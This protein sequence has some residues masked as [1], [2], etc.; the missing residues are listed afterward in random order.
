MNSD[1]ALVSKRFAARSRLRY[2]NGSDLKI[3]RV[4][5]PNRF[6]YLTSRNVPVR[7]Q[8]VLGRI[9]RL[10]IP[11]AWTD[12]RICRDPAGHLQAVGR[13]ARGR[14]QYRYHDRWSRLRNENK[15]DRL[16]D[17]G[18]VLPKIRRA[19]SRDLRQPALTQ[20]KVLAAIVRLLESS[21][22]RVGNEEYVAQN[23]SYGL[24][25]LRNHHARVSG[26][27][28]KLRFRGKSG[29]EQEIGIRDPALARIVRKC[30]H[31]PGQRL[32][33]YADDDGVHAVSS[34]D[35]NDYLAGITGQSFTAKDFRTWE[36]TALATLTL[37]R[38]K[39][40]GLKARR[41]NIGEAIAQAAKHLGNTPAICKKCYIHPAILERYLKDA[42]ASLPNG[43]KPGIRSRSGLATEE[44]ALLAW[45]R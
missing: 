42:L 26:D 2:V 36:A 20:Q 21:A 32:F 15:F 35:V 39:Q 27:T 11:P 29:K 24:T 7:D 43:A 18:R 5:A 23:G 9:E 25:T 16:V 22:A 44:K 3:Q 14:K 19:V 33:E 41:G 17:F 8:A 1:A 37:L 40:H 28:L 38:A 30:Q 6:R 4:G 34:D 13:D 31:L 10:A 12:V 45:L